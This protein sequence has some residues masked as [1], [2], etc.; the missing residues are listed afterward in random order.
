MVKVSNYLAEIVAHSA[1]RYCSRSVH[2]G[3]GCINPEHLINIRTNTHQT[4]W[5]HL[6]PY[7]G[8]T[9]IQLLKPGLI[10][11]YPLSLI[12]L[13]FNNFC[14]ERDDWYQNNIQYW[15]ELLL[16]TWLAQKRLQINVNVALCLLGMYTGNLRARSEHDDI[17][18]LCPHLVIHICP[19]WPN[20]SNKFWGFYSLNTL[21]S[22][23]LKIVLIKTCI[24]RWRK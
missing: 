23:S 12:T 2:E 10:L 6:L 22:R 8:S 4:K 11:T 1:A 20:K 13:W 9:F 14:T 3:Q 24:E 15:Q 18:L 19:K 16:E 7:N 21:H 17:S 5:M